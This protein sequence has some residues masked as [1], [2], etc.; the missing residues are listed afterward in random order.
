MEILMSSI[1]SLAA[2]SLSVLALALTSAG[3]AGSEDDSAPASDEGNFTS[4]A[5]RDGGRLETFEGLDG[6]SYFRLVAANGLKLL[7]SEAYER[8]AGPEQAM[9][10]LLKAAAENNT[11]RF[12]VL[13]AAAGGHYVSVSGA[14]T[15]TEVI[16]TSEVYSSKS[17]A[18]DAAKM[19]VGY[20]KG[21]AKVEHRAAE[22]G[23]RFD[24][25]KVPDAD[26]PSVDGKLQAFKF[27]L[28]AKNGETVLAS[29][30]YA[31]KQAAEDGIKAVKDYGRLKENYDVSDLSRGR[32]VFNLIARKHSAASD[33]PGGAGNNE[34]VGFSEVYGQKS[35]A[36]RGADAVRDALQ[37]DVDVNDATR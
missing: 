26:A 33:T 34:A 32:A 13:P 29:E 31:S 23:K 24:L 27:V 35:D 5:K 37:A 20:L 21:I 16:A 12:E 11:R 28:R 7:R 6:K 14:G 18:N 36:Q 22:T 8:S 10:S 2:V 30:F 17:K 19:I 15:S 9:D 4:S 25:V 3:C 1:R